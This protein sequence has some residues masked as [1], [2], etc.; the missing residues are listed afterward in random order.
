MSASSR[1]I[2][3]HWICIGDSGEVVT[4]FMHVG[5][6]PTKNFATFGPSELQPPF[7]EVSIQCLHISS[8]LYSTG[9]TSDP[10]HHLTISQ[11]P[12]FLLN[13]RY[14]RFCYTY[15]N[16]NFVKYSLSRSYRVILPSSFNIVISYALVFST[17]SPVSDLIRFKVV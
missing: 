7:T 6:Y 15:Q 2:Q 8:S 14:P 12:V 5:T 3:F 13:S 17:N 9:Q 4:P 1:T 11:S 16:K 10:I